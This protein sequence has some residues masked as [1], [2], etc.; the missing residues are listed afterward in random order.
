MKF[1]GKTFVIILLVLLFFGV[2]FTQ[3]VSKFVKDVTQPASKPSMEPVKAA[4]IVDI[5]QTVQETPSS[6]LPNEIPVTDNFGEFSA[7]DILSNQ[8]YLDPRSQIGYPGTV[9]GVLRNANLQY[10]SEPM[11]PRDPVSIFNLSTITPDTMRA[12]FEIGSV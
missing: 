12:P 2:V 4:D 11:N 1:D 6:L 9:G 3:S 7:Q 8:N 5:P 10:R